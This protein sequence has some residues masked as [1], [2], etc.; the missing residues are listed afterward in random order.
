M[1]QGCLCQH[2]F[3]PR[4]A[5]LWNSLPIECFRLTYNLNGFNSWINRHLLTVGS[6]PVCCNLFVLLFLVISC[7]LVALK[8][9]LE[10]IPIEKK[11]ER[12]KRKRSETISDNWKPFENNG[13]CVLF[14]FKSSF[15]PQDISDF[16]M[17]FWSCTKTTWL[18]R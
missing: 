3:F 5:K 9:W 7:L 2:F 10:C 1:L 11:K 17:I 12:R 6:F 14:H 4:T 13:K 16:L 18:E 15:C 8:P